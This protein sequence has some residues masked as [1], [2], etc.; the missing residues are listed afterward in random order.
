[1]D[2]SAAS[3][4]GY[5]VAIYALHPAPTI[6]NCYAASVHAYHLSGHILSLVRCIKQKGPVITHRALTLFSQVT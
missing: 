6:R 1:L 5:H 3:R 2:A 4:N